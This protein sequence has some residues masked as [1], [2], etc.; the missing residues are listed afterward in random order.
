MLTCAICGKPMQECCD[1]YHVAK[2]KQGRECVIC[3]DCAEELEAYAESHKALTEE[4]T[5]QMQ[6]KLLSVDENERI[7]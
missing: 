4:Q 1:I 7:L 5:E 2:N 6:A 3:G